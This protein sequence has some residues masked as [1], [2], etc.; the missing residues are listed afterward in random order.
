[1]TVTRAR[2]PDKHDCV[3]LVLWT[4]NCE[5]HKTAHIKDSQALTAVWGNQSWLRRG[6]HDAVGPHNRLLELDDLLHKSKRRALQHLGLAV[7]TAAQAMPS[8]LAMPSLTTALVPALTTTR[9]P[10]LMTLL[11]PVRTVQSQRMSILMGQMGAVPSVSASDDGVVQLWSQAL[12]C[13]VSSWDVPLGIKCARGVDLSNL[14][15]KEGGGWAKCYGCSLADGLL[16]SADDHTGHGSA[17]ACAH[18]W[19][20]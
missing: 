9:P 19:G 15:R 20:F 12:C 3:M 5:G 4:R 8:P 11:T 1:M 2:Q 18:S 13:P 7:S 6:H 14:A 16:A 17:D 10:S